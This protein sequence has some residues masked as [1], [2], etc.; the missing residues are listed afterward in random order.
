MNV[1]LNLPSD[2]ESAARALASAQGEDIETFLVRQ[3]ALTLKPQ[4][5]G[6]VAAAKHSPSESIVDRL[7]RFTAMHRVTGFVD[8]SRESIYSGRE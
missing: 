6:N 4:T 3:I 5:E 7:N 2:L 8:D 1:M